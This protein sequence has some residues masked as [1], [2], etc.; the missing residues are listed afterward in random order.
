NMRSQIVIGPA[1]IASPRSATG[2]A[3]GIPPWRSVPPMMSQAE[4]GLVEVD[5]SIAAADRNIQQIASLLPDLA[6]RGY[7]HV[8]LE[9]RLTLRTQPLHPLRAQRRAIIETLDGSE[10]LPRIVRPRH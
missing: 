1:S 9:R 8:E 4:I 5:E 10:P 3:A 2:G 7:A 6:G